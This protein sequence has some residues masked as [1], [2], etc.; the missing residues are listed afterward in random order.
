[1]PMMFKYGSIIFLKENV[2]S[3]PKS[4]IASTC[5]RMRYACLK[6]FPGT[7]SAQIN[8]KEHL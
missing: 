4:Q 2:C 3:E 6:I 1:M 7:C 8:S 5:T